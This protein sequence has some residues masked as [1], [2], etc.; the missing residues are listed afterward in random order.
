MSDIQIVTMVGVHHHLPDIGN[1]LVT[2]KTQVKYFH[3]IKQKQH[4]PSVVG[5][6]ETRGIR[7][8]SDQWYR[9]IPP[10]PSR[11]FPG[12][13]IGLVDLKSLI[14]LREG[15]YWTTLRKID[16][17]RA[18][19]AVFTPRALRR[20]VISESGFDD[21][22]MSFIDFAARQMSNHYAFG[23]E[24]FP[25]AQS[26]VERLTILDELLEI[27]SDCHFGWHEIDALIALKADD[28]LAHEWDEWKKQRLEED[29]LADPQEAKRMAELEEQMWDEQLREVWIQSGQWRD[30]RFD[31]GDPSTWPERE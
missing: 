7:A 9:Y 1:D 31:P 11:G 14:A 12:G 20:T 27:R 28:E 24:L 19:R 10:D 8:T 29:P 13:T 25:D 17:Q 26:L 5:S 6:I 18:W 16:A 23:Y 3:D 4:R 21:S 2:F 15:R 22:E 30:D